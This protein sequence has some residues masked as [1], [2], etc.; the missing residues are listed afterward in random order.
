MSSAE[1]AP[2]DWATP[3]STLGSHHRYRCRVI[4]RRRLGW[5]AATLTAAF[6]VIAVAVG[7]GAL[8]ALDTWIAPLMVLPLGTAGRRLAESIN[9]AG[10]VSIAGLAGLAGLVLAG[11]RRRRTWLILLAPLATFPVELLAKNVVPQIGFHNFT[12]FQL[13]SFLAIPTPYTFPSGSM[14][15]ITALIFALLLHPTGARLVRVR[16]GSEERAAVLTA[17]ALAVAAWGHLAA[18]D[19]WPSDI[20][21]GLILGAAAAFALGWLTWRHDASTA[22]PASGRAPWRPEG[23]DDISRSSRPASR[24]SRGD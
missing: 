18:A 5:I 13:G 8:E 7:T 20:L 2:A 22:P 23:P 19:H 14:A 3:R 21:A 9:L 15:R 24:D 17:A 4:A 12:E 6:A 10:D 1:A 16:I 11:V